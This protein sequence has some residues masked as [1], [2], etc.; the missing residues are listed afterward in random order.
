MQRFPDSR[1]IPDAKLKMGYIAQEQ[2]DLEAARALF[3]EVIADYPDSQAAGLAK[4][5]L[6]RMGGE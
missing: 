5:R 2:D 6:S 4:Q 3:N 1:R